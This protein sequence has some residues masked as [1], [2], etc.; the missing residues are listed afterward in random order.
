MAT[1]NREVLSA[2]YRAGALAAKERL[3]ES[4]ID[5]TIAASKT[6]LAPYRL[7]RD[8]SESERANRLLGHFLAPSQIGINLEAL[9]GLERRAERLAKELAR[10]N[11]LLGHRDEEAKNDV[12]CMNNQDIEL[13]GL[14]ET[15]TERRTEV[16][17]LRSFILAVCLYLAFGGH[18]TKEGESGLAAPFAFVRGLGLWAL[19]RFVVSAILC[20]PMAWTCCRNALDIAGRLWSIIN[21]SDD[22]R[23]PAHRLARTQPSLAARIKD[24]YEV[25]CPEKLQD[26]EFC[27]RIAKKYSYPGG[28]EAL[29]DSLKKRYS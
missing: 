18:L 9:D 17:V 10:T 25:H 27:L 19:S 22:S 5:K 26:P 7:R 21:K 3:E 15:A 8:E 14:R 12:Q 29:F 11:S 16:Y 1:Y 23:E 13:D 6:F 2:Q 24:F 4:K 20:A 28:P